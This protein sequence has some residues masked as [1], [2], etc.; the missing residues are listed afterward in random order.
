M[1]SLE[2]FGSDTNTINWLFIAFVLSILQWFITFGFLYLHRNILKTKN[3][4][5]DF[6]GFL[7]HIGFLSDH[8]YW[9]WNLFPIIFYLHF[10]YIE[11][12]WNSW[13]VSVFL[14][15]I[16]NQISLLYTQFFQS[17]LALY[18]DLGVLFFLF[19]ASL[20][21]GYTMQDK[22]YQKMLKDKSSLYWW[23]K[24]T[25]ANLYFIRKIFLVNNLILV[26]FLTYLITKISIFL[27]FILRL[28]TLNIFPFHPDGYGGFHVFMQSFSILIGMYLLRGSMGIIG[29]DD[30]KGQGISHLIGDI[31]NTVYLPMSLGLFSFMFIDI[32]RHMNVAFEKYKL[33]DYLSSAHYGTFLNDYLAATDKASFLNNFNDYYEILKQNAFPIDI[34]LFYNAIATIVLPISF[35]F[36]INH[37]KEKLN[38]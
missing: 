16:D 3:L 15:D 24:K 7:R 20:Y 13:M 1:F 14:L 28:D 27:I 9:F 23:A 12:A 17:N 8:F 33:S 34:A 36:L 19:F 37:Y 38:A 18:I 2:Y 4:Q 35:W 25:N 29:L 10:F 30:H 26:G 6:P 11:H 31:L 32:T 5:E 22:K 21:F